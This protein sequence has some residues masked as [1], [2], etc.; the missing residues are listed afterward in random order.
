[1]LLAIVQSNPELARSAPG[2]LP[3]T[4]APNGS[5]IDTG[6]LTRRMSDTDASPY[7]LDVPVDMSA[8]D[9]GGNAKQSEMTDDGEPYMFIPADPRSCYRAIV[10]EALSYD[11]SERHEDGE[12][13]TPRLLSKK[14]TELLNEIGLRWR[15][16]Y[17]SRMLLLLDVARERFVDRQMDLDTLDAA[18]NYVKE[19][20]PESKKKVDVSQL[21]DRNKWTMMDFTLNQQI[22]KSIDDMLL[23]DLF[24]QFMHCYEAK[25]PNIGPIMTILETHIYEDPLYSRNHDDLDRFS[26]SLREAL[27]DKAKD[28]YNFLHDSEIGQNMDNVKFYHIIQLGKAA[29]KFVERIQKRYRKNPVI[30]GWV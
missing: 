4:R 25:A 28:Q 17:I 30:M 8:L 14:S 9:L 5:A 3:P 19:P 29:L 1:M 10:K 18:F 13:G 12:N 21:H 6:D 23:R 20:P 15:I 22:L 24:E 26:S 7:I 11:M 16:P 2:A 27:Y